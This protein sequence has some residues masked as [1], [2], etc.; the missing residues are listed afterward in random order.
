[1][2]REQ[3]ADS[4]I[5]LP[6]ESIPFADFSTLINGILKF[7]TETFM[8][9]MVGT[10]ASLDSPA[11]PFDPAIVMIFNETDRS[12]HFATPT[13]GAGKCFSIK[14]AVAFVASG[15]I[16]IG[17]KKFTLGTDADLNAA[18]DALH[19]VAIAARPV[20]GGA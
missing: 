6:K 2:A 7:G 19:F 5:P 10:G 11:L 13:T 18:A 17:T 14:A 16:T 15:G 1:M 12:M 8:G 3:Y 20:S 9:T 4:Q